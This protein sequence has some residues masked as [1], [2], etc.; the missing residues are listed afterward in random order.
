MLHDLNLNSQV[1]D[2]L[3]NVAFIPQVIPDVAIPS[4]K[5]SVDEDFA[6]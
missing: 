5:V 2:V 1:R 6:V 3:G 4:G